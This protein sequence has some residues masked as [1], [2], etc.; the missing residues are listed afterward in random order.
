MTRRFSA[1]FLFLS[2][3]LLMV[4][5]GHARKVKHSLYIDKEKKSTK[6]QT[7]I[8][9]GNVVNLSDSVK[10]CIFAGYDKEPN[11]SVESF[12]VINPTDSLLTGFEVTIEYQDMQGRMLHSRKVR[13]ACEVPP[14]ESRRVDIP[15]WDKQHTYYYYLGN[16]PRRVATP[17]QVVFRPIAIWMEEFSS[18]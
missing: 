4:M 12:L 14:N 7:E 2:A 6:L 8:I 17:F 16:Q 18:E 15:T 10:N 5:P 9:P 1:V 11:S 3:A 13:K